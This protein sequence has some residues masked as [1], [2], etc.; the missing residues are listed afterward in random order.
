M[1]RNVNTH[2]A[3]RADYEAAGWNVIDIEHQ[4]DHDTL[5][6]LR[7][8]LDLFHGTHELCTVVDSPEWIWR[9]RV[10]YLLEQAEAAQ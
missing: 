1:T 2:D 10:A 6:L 7:E 9:W 4:I 5:A 8:A 3:H